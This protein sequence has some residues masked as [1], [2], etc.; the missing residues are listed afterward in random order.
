MTTKQRGP[1][2]TKLASNFTVRDYERAR[3]VRDRRKIAD[4]IRRRFLERYLD[5]VSTSTRKHGFTMMAVSCLMIEAL[6]SFRQGWENSRDKGKSAF[7]FFFDTASP[8]A[9]FSG[10]ASNFYVHVRCGILHQAE[11]TGGWT[12]RRSGPL[13]D[14]STNTINATTFVVTLK[15]F[16]EEYC[17]ELEAKP[18]DGVEWKRVRIKMNA[19]VRNCQA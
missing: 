1:E 2:D 12:V 4:A 18:W 11:T 13:F 15:R 6:E 3:E 9:V 5:P 8:F 19:I 17:F 16:L 10:Q 7:C 14:P